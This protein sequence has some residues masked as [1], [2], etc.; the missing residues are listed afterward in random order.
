M[1]KGIVIFL[2]SACYAFGQ[3]F[4]FYDQA[5]LGNLL[6]SAP[7]VPIK[8]Y[9]YLGMTNLANGTIP[10]NLTVAG[11]LM[12]PNVTSGNTSL[13]TGSMTNCYIT[14]GIAPLFSTP[15]SINGTTYTG[16]NAGV[17]VMNATATF[18]TLNWQYP[19]TI[20]T[21]LIMWGFFMVPNEAQVSGSDMDI[22]GV[23]FV[24]GHSY[25]MQLNYSG[26]TNHLNMESS[27]TAYA[28]LHGNYIWYPTNKWEGFC[29]SFAA[30][31]FG[32]G[33]TNGV[34]MVYLYDE[35]GGILNTNFGV[36]NNIAAALSTII[37]GNNEGGYMPQ[38]LFYFANIA[39]ASQT[40]GYPAFPF[41]P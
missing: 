34:G 21:N 23:S 30:G 39:I 14:N 26:G 25:I 29:A 9:A 7:V 18:T 10:T 19:S 12:I 15:I 22:L 8:A 6:L 33:T 32:G 1:V 41:A 4:T 3:S 31:Q 2:L 38:S 27:T 5:W 24:T 16:T 36:T 28:T 11:R 37:I 17:L 20:G 40:N 35:P 13:G